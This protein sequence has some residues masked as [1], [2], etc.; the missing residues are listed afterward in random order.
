MQVSQWVWETR[1]PEKHK[2]MLMHDT[3]FSEA[4]AG[5]LFS[6]LVGLHD[7]GKASPDFSG[8]ENTVFRTLPLY[9]RMRQQ[10]FSYRSFDL[11]RKSEY[12]KTVRHEVASEFYIKNFLHSKHLKYTAPTV[13]AIISAHHGKPKDMNPGSEVLFDAMMVPGKSNPDFLWVESARLIYDFIIGYDEDYEPI[14]LRSM[15]T[16]LSW[17]T[18]MVFSGYLS[19]SDWLASTED[20]FPLLSF[21][22]APSMSWGTYPNRTGNAIQQFKIP[23]VFD[24]SK[25]ALD[26]DTN[27]I[28]NAR[29]GF[30][31][32]REVQSE[33]V[34]LAKDESTDPNDIF[35]LEAPM[36]EGKTEACLVA[37]EIL[38]GRSKSTGMFFGLPTMATGEAIYA[39]VAPYIESLTDDTEQYT[40]L[41]LAHSKSSFS[42]NKEATQREARN[43]KGHGIV[44]TG[45]LSGRYLKTLNSF[46][47]GT[48]D[49]LLMM[50]LK[51]SYG[52]W[53]QLGFS[54]KVIIVDEVH[55][56]DEVMKHYLEEALVMA[57]F[58]GCPVILSS[59][60]LLTSERKAYIEAYNLGKSLGES[61]PYGK[62]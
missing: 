40:S 25:I 60:T 27:T 54:Q 22:D 14:L 3:G 24:Y 56:M 37:G 20:Y 2:E 29:F 50:Q 42:A 28:F 10:G 12:E 9:N 41:E 36:G 13:L 31:T 47:V 59:A 18:Q 46:V 23:S 48:V 44:P 8:R 38:M 15:E 16:G 17:R 52:Y 7:L 45:W 35:I 57:G 39:R 1:V 55:S 6:V 21:D 43:N 62:N 32:P 19:L 4:D 34:N 5:K 11:Q 53:R 58:Y 49:N 30:D 33:L 26:T 61:I 51:A